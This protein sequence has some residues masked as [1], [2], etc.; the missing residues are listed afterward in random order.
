MR[1]VILDIMMLALWKANMKN[2][3]VA[4]HEG[5]TAAKLRQN[6]GTLYENKQVEESSMDIL[7]GYREQDCM[8]FNL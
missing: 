8:T 2:P 7:L 3:E 1:W 5:E 6:F 4:S